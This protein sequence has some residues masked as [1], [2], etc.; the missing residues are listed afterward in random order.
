[1]VEL[2]KTRSVQTVWCLLR[3]Q[4]ESNLPASRLSRSSMLPI[5][6]SL[7]PYEPNSSRWT[8]A[9]SAFSVGRFLDLC[10][11]LVFVWRMSTAGKS[12]VERAQ[13]QAGLA[14]PYTARRRPSP[15][16]E[17]P[18][19]RPLSRRRGNFERFWL[20]LHS[21]WVHFESSW[22]WKMKGKGPICSRKQRPQQL[23]RILENNRVTW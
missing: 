6:A 15:S 19:F 5:S 16:R 17:F 4:V 21:E 3:A 13:R 23:V 1:M 20:A 10:L 12:W 8:I 22:R 18:P 2:P 7:A 9:R 14:R 11:A